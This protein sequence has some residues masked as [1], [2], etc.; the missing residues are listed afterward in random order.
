MTDEQEVEATEAEQPG[1][2]AEAVPGDSLIDAVEAEPVEVDGAQS[3]PEWFLNKF[4]SVE[5]Q[6]KAYTDLEK[7]FHEKLGAFTGA[8]EEDY[9]VP[10]VEGLDPGVMEDNP[11]IAWFKESAREADMSQEA[12]DRFLTGYLA[13]EQEMISTHRQRELAALGDKAK[14]RL[15][16]LADWGQGNLSA[17]QWE[18]FKGVAS[19][20][21]GVELLESMIGR[22]R[23]AKL[24]RD[25]QSTQS[26]GHT[27]AEELRQMRYAKTETG[28][29]RMSVDPE[30]KKQVDRAY[31]EA[32]GTAA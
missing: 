22:T 26:S 9:Q 12:F 8:P 5:D 7:T 2:A 30:Y 27:T 20:A 10:Q 24:A 14:S 18:I 21:V 16:D 15:T 31:Q 3:V 6:A 1:L 28:H 13:T 23:E 19:T 32:Y 11:M 25:P 29:L 17:D 4:K